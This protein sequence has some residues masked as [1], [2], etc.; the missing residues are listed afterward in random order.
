MHGNVIPTAAS[1]ALSYHQAHRRVVPHNVDPI[2]R[3]PLHSRIH[4]LPGSRQGSP[5]S[6]FPSHRSPK[7]Q[8]IFRVLVLLPPPIKQKPFRHR[9][10]PRQRTRSPLPLSN[11]PEAY[12]S[13]KAREGGERGSGAVPWECVCPFRVGP[14][15]LF[16]LGKQRKG[17]RWRLRRG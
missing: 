15:Q 17:E 12:P 7:F 8:L 4:R 5:H 3:C 13:R 2:T 9:P 16:W 14:A 10:L 11:D 1:H 6:P